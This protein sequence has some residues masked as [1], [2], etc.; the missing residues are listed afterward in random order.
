MIFHTNYRRPKFPTPRNTA[1]RCVSWCRKFETTTVGVKH[2]GLIPGQVVLVVEVVGGGKRHGL[3][4]SIL[5][6]V[7]TQPARDY[8]I[9]CM[10]AW[11]QEYVGARSIA[12]VC[13]VR[14]GG[15]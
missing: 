2:F 9:V 5:T 13:G 11:L 10:H 15:C 12:D 6:A 4:M 8:D 3:I 14:D 7:V 1:P